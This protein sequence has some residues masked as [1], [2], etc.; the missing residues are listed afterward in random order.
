M[1]QFILLNRVK[2]QNANAIAGFTWGFPAV[3]NFLGFTHNLSRKISKKNEYE[4]IHLLGC[5]V[6]AHNHQVHAYQ[7]VERKEFP[8]GSGDYKNFIGDVHFSQSRNPA[9]QHKEEG[10]YKVG[11]P[12]VIEEGKMNMTVSL[13]IA[14][15]GDLAAQGNEFCDWIKSLC[16]TQ[17]LAGGTILDIAD[18]SIKDIDEDYDGRS[19]LQKLKRKLLPG[20]I[21]KDRSD[22]LTAHY[23]YLQKENANTELLEVWLDFSALKRKARPKCDLIFQHLQQQVKTKKLDESVLELWL[24]HLDRTYNKEDIPER[25]KEH[26][27]ILDKKGSEDDLLAQWQAYYQ[28]DEQTLADWEYLKKPNS[29]WLVP[30]MTGYKAISALY[31][32]ADVKGIRA[33]DDDD[34]VE[35]VSFVESVH[36]IGEWLSVHKLSMEGSDSFEK[37]EDCIWR[38]APYEKDWYL[39]TQESTQQAQNKT[40]KP[41]Y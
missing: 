17:R 31:D 19:E 3:T 7:P 9:Y 37:L 30:I 20:F 25:V 38:Y 29:G 14:Y 41:Q 28:P 33:K 36:S 34:S 27:T 5:A 13:L 18:V 15:E 1:K 26:F 16:L 24:D 11:T 35:K 32:K 40:N 23:E 2:V 12:P 39:C 21:L 22:Y 8:K 4:D 6:I 10:K